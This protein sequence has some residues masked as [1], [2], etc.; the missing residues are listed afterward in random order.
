MLY[1]CVHICWFQY[2]RDMLAFHG[3][4]CFRPETLSLN[5]HNYFPSFHSVNLLVIGSEY[6]RCFYW[7]TRRNDLVTKSNAHTRLISWRDTAYVKY[8]SIY[9]N[10]IISI[11]NCWIIFLPNSPWNHSLIIREK[12]ISAVTHSSIYIYSVWRIIHKH[13]QSRT[14]IIITYVK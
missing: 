13:T 7:L 10:P 14:S 2:Q 4:R 6:A 8:I 1:I 3:S 5:V 12:S 9:T 11:R